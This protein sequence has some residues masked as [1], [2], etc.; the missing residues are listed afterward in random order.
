VS[1]WLDPPVVQEKHQQKDHQS[2]GNV[3][4]KRLVVPCVLH[5]LYY[6]FW[7]TVPEN[8]ILEHVEQ[9]QSKIALT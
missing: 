8:L 3:V 4:E 5:S 2:S 9:Q 7:Y 1:C 6:W